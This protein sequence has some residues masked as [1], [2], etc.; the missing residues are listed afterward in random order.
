MMIRRI[1]ILFLLVVV[2][3][4]ALGDD[5]QPPSFRV[6]SYNIRH[7]HHVD[8]GVKKIRSVLQSLKPDIL[9]LQEA[10]WQRPRRGSPSGHPVIFATALGDYEWCAASRPRRPGGQRRL[11]PAIVVRGKII[12]SEPLSVDGKSDYAVLAEVDIDGVRLIVVAGHFH[13][14]SQASVAGA[15]RTE[16]DRMREAAHLVRRLRG[17]TL[18]VVIGVDLNALPIFP[19][20]KSLAA[21]YTDVARAAGDESYTRMTGSIPTRIDYVFVSSAFAVRTYRVV[22]VDYSDHRPVFVDLVLKS[23]KREN[24]SDRGK[25]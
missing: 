4:R 12:R 11:G 13:S 14:L 19:T 22:K 7:G 18:P 9:C 6:V 15:V 23:K 3:A 1:T 5:A 21:A 20:Y 24:S 16:A 17:E 8:Q 10:T 2:P 25:K